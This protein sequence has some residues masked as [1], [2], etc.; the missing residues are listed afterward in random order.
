M[1][2]VIVPEAYR[3][4]TKGVGEIKV[5]TGSVREAVEAV[6]AE[7]EGFLA[8]VLDATGN[9]HKFVKLFIN[10]EQLDVGGLDTPLAEDDRLEVLAA[11]TGG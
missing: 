1:P 3:G 7:H 5:H 6:E 11:I 2:S 8:L 10:E 9:L 4:P